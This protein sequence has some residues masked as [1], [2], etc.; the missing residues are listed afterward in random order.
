MNILIAMTTIL[1]EVT[2]Y[3]HQTNRR[4]RH[5]IDLRNLLSTI[6]HYHSLPVNS[7]EFDGSLKH[8]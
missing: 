3:A 2:V 4:R 1:L 7:L 5:P 6:M 8:F